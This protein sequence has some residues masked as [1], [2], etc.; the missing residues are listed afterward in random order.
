MQRPGQ[1]RAVLAVRVPLESAEGPSCTV[2]VD[3]QSG[4]VQT[5]LSA[6]LRKLGHRIWSPETDSRAVIAV[7]MEAGGGDEAARVGRM[8]AAHPRA[9]LIAIGGPAMSDLFDSVCPQP[10]DAKSLEAALAA[11]ERSQ[12]QAN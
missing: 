9:R 11:T 6:L 1:G 5:V 8:R 12:L 3:A 10:V 7:L 4:T 2:R